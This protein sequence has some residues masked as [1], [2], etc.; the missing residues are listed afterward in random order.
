MKK[1]PVAAALLT[2]MIL[3]AGVIGKGGGFGEAVNADVRTDDETK[4]NSTEN[5]TSRIDTSAAVLPGSRIAV[6][7]KCVS[8]EFWDMVYKEWMPQLRILIQL[9]DLKQRIRLK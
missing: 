7:S 2:G 6:V 5:N 4:E 1:A 8:G 9:M 3:A